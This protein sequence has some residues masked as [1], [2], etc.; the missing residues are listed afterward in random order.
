M[1][2]AEFV[3]PAE[4]VERRPDTTRLGDYRLVERIGA[5]GM[6]VVHLGVDRTG[7]AVAVKVLR[8]HVAA[9]DSA[10]ERLAREFDS[11]SRVAHPAVAGIVDA[12]LDGERPYLVTRYVPGRAL[13]DWISTQGALSGPRLL[14][15]GETL[16]TA[17][18][19]VHAAGVV[20]R[21]LKPSNV[22]MSDGSPVV[23]DFG[24]AHIADESRLTRTGLVMGTPG[25]IAPELLDE[26]DVGEA[27]DWW[28]WAAT[29]GFAATGRLPFGRGPID[30]V[31]HRVYRGEAD[32]AGVEPGLAELI[33]ACLDP[34]PEYRPDRMQITA[35][36]AELERGGDLTTLLGGSSARDDASEDTTL[37]GDT[38]RIDPRPRGVADEGTTPL[39]A[40]AASTAAMPAV[41]RD[42]GTAAMPTGGTPGRAPGWSSRPGDGR[43]S[44]PAR[45][46][47]TPIIA[48]ATMPAV[49]PG[50]VRPTWNYAGFRSAP[51]AA[52]A[53]A[54]APVGPEAGWAGGPPPGSGGPV[55]RAPDGSPPGPSGAYAGSPAH[56]GGIRRGRARSVLFAGG[57][58]FVAAT[59]GFPLVALGVA[60]IWAVLAR[61]VDA[62]VT[63]V[64]LRRHVRGTA[65]ASDIVRA[66]VASPLRLVGAALTTLLLAVLQAF[67]V[68][69]SLFAVAVTGELFG[70]R[71]VSPF[72]EFALAGAAVVAWVFAWWGPGG[73][74]LR[75][76][77][78]RIV[79][80][81]TPG[82]WTAVTVALVLLLA[83]AYLALRTQGSGVVP[84]WW[85]VTGVPEVSWQLPW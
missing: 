72:G 43:S 17:L 31:F 58:L 11:L 7:R 6:G 36:L 22:L 52:P 19:A 46:T 18:D 61:T 27:T 13:D 84:T 57:L 71:S 40:S 50:P 14:R 75:N 25:F 48:T 4:G 45:T 68:V 65:R 32:L 26:S 30:A 66:V 37:L 39:D 55:L 41:R 82:R 62:S 60:L 73:R 70:A 56:V 81:L 77:S 28:G 74:A 23:I 63:A 49:D 1:S 44:E 10:R 15:F 29:L 38:T 76:G 54:F 2:T 42:P 16:A 8:D 79:A 83:A 24:I 21:D 78:T 33:R 67:V 35:A 9:D 5:G 12:D 80:S 64:V 51:A 3:T 85:P 34:R 20:H 69:P 53:P 59:A 47:S